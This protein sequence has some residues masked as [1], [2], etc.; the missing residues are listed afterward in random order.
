MP[1]VLTGIG[2][3]VAAFAVG[4]ALGSATSGPAQ[5]PTFVIFGLPVLAYAVF[6]GRKGTGRDEILSRLGLVRGAF[7]YYLVAVAIS[8]VLA[9]FNRLAVALV[10]PTYDP[11]AVYSGLDPGPATAVLALL[12]ESLNV[13]LGEE[14]LCRGL[15]A[16]W[17][18]RRFGF[19]AGNALQTLVFLLPHLLLLFVD[20]SLLPFVLIAALVGGWIFGWLRYRSGSIWPGWLLHSL[21]NALGKMP[22]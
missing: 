12:N 1:L 15:I 14:L 19:Y 3:T 2:V 6:L 7:A 4:I 9:V 13:A 8:V 5:F 22:L 17:A 11:G 21:G 16:G 10:P 20:L 18:M